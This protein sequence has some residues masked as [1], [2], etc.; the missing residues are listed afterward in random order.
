MKKFL[1]SAVVVLSFLFYSLNQ[2][3]GVIES[4][5][6]V[7]NNAG[8]PPTAGSS[9]SGYKDG[10]YTGSA[11]DAFYGNIQVVAVISQGR[12]TDVTFLQYPND[13]SRSVDINLQ[14]MPMLKSEAITAQSG[15]VDIISGA[16]DTSQAFIQSMISALQQAKL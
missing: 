10:T 4:L 14:A 12:I 15:N 1:L 13:R 6:T 11:A 3:K 8:N 7:I 16:T 9:K 2:K 5:P